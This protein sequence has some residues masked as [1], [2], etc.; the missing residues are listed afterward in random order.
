MEIFF[1]FSMIDAHNL[2]PY[3]SRQK[4]SSC[5]EKTIKLFSIFHLKLLQVWNSFPAIYRFTTETRLFSIVIIL[6]GRTGKSGAPRETRLQPTV[7]GDRARARRSGA[8]AGRL[9]PSI[10]PCCRRPEQRLR[11]PFQVLLASEW[12]S[13]VHRKSQF[14]GADRCSLCRFVQPTRGISQRLKDNSM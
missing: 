1:E 2:F 11:T 4:L 7:P 14:D 8:T 13:Q 10:A 5:V 3:H 12:M 9:A 6:S